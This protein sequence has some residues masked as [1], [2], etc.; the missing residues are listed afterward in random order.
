MLLNN[1]KNDKINEECGIFGG[2]CKCGDIAP[3]LKCALLKLQHRGQEAAGIC[4]GGEKQTLHKDF[5]LVN[6]ALRN[7]KI[8]GNF[9]IGHLRYST[10][11]DSRKENIQPLKVSYMG[12]DVSLAHNGN[13][14]EARAIREKFERIGEVFLSS[15]DSEVI[16][17]RIIFSLKKNPSL[18]TY[19]EVAKCLEENFSLGSYCILLYLPNRIMA[20]RDPFGYRPLVFASCEEGDF[21]ASEDVAFYG[22]N[23]KRTVEI[24]PSYGVEIN[25]SGYEIKKA[26]ESKNVC[27]CVFEQIYFACAASNIFSKSVYNSRYK[28]G[29]I[30]AGCESKKFAADVAI[31]VMDSGLACAIG[32]SW[33][34]KI[35]FH[36]GLI[37][38]SW[39]ERSFIQPEQ[40]KRTKNVLEKFIPVRSVVEGKK[41]VLIDDSL[42]RGTTSKEIIKI[43]KSCGA[44]EVHMRSVSPK[45]VNTCLWGV[46]I[47]TK[48]ELISYNKTDVEIARQ[49]GADSVGFL[50]LERLSDVFCGNVWCKKCFKGDEK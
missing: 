10:F 48:E 39:M 31:P 17:K 36:L 46:D 38:N 25:E 40:N 32:Y 37:R 50:P 12:E 15:S 18:W 34:L 11:G 44:K 7:V 49:I 14:S 5:G 27:Q 6:V 41:V 19:E 8:K 35:P 26:Q 30:L 42:V 21:V 22:L 4:C 24:L 45:I 28:L 43:L 2:Y 16:L 20:F 29:E 13:V 23:V 1:F 33:A 3:Y 47:P 9:G